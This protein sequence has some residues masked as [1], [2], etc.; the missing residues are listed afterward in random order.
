MCET[1]WGAIR[2]TVK[3]LPKE[4][5]L[6]RAKIR[7]NK[8]YRGKAIL[9]VNYFDAT[10]ASVNSGRFDKELVF[11]RTKNYQNW[12]RQAFLTEVP[13]GAVTMKVQLHVRQQG[14]GEFFSIDDFDCRRLQK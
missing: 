8:A 12:N 4:M 7:Y 14:R 6:F 10:G 13:E 2:Q 1:N 3:V 5:Y 9:A 11:D